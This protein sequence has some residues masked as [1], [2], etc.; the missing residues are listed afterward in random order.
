MEVLHSCNVFTLLEEQG[1]SQRLLF[2]C[3]SPILK[4]FKKEFATVIKMDQ[5]ISEEAVGLWSI[6]ILH[7]CRR[8]SVTFHHFSTSKL[9]TLAL[10]WYSLE[11]GINKNLTTSFL[12]FS[13]Q[14]CPENNQTHLIQ[15]GWIG[16]H[17]L[18]GALRLLVAVTGRKLHQFFYQ[19]NV[20]PVI[21][22]PT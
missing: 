10:D 16:K 9:Y 15:G 2:W 8:V 18:A 14:L 7:D 21:D 6:Q 4:L 12:I 1:I 13:F 22:R 3:L 19:L 17:A 20:F 11:S 5:G